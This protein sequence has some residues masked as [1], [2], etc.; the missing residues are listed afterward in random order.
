MI[1]MHIAATTFIR[2]I[3]TSFK[4]WLRFK[5]RDALWL[6]VPADKALP[7]QLIKSF[8]RGHSASSSSCS[9]AP[10]HTKFGGSDCWVPTQAEIL[11]S[12]HAIQAN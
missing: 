2:E 7:H 1:A 12:T 9:A 4:G 10:G 6:R 3:I 5:R 11:P 8:I